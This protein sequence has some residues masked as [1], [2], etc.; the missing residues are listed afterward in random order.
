MFKMATKS[1]CTSTVVLSPDPLSLT[2]STSSATKTPVD[3]EE[4]PDDPKPADE[5]DIQME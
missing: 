5:E 4:D 1:A 3:T 2:A